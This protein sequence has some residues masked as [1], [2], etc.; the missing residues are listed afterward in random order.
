MEFL[1]IPQKVTKV[2]KLSSKLPPV[3]GNSIT[4]HPDAVPDGAKRRR[5][6]RRRAGESQT[7][8]DRRSTGEVKTAA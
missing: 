2:I 3:E 7:G 8:G 5:T 4:L 6:G 1:F